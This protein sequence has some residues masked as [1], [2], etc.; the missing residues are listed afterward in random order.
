ML[1]LV[2]RIRPTARARQ[3][4][5]AFWRWV[6]ERTAWFYDGMDM[7]HDPRWFVCT[8][9][10]DVHSLEHVVTF[11]DEAAWGRYRQEVHRRAQDPQ[12]EGARASQDEWWELLDALLLDDAP[13]N[14]SGQ[15]GTPSSEVRS[16]G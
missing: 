16:H 4:M 10:Q 13:V 9:G 2:Y 7:A 12:W 8:V 3:D 1:H 5:A 14:T 11:A 6:G 15:T